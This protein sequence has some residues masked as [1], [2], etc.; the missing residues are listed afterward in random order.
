MLPFGR[1]AGCWWKGM[2]IA[3]P[4]DLG[5]ALAPGGCPRRPCRCFEPP[6]VVRRSFLDGPVRRSY[7][8]VH[9]DGGRRDDLIS[10]CCGVCL[11]LRPPFRGR[12]SAE[13]GSCYRYGHGGPGRGSPGP[14]PAESRCPCVGRLDCGK[15]GS[16]WCAPAAV[17]VRPGPCPGLLVARA[18]FLNVRHPAAHR[19]GCVLPDGG[20]L[21]VVTRSPFAPLLVRGVFVSLPPRDAPVVAHWTVVR[22]FLRLLRQRL[23]LSWEGR[24]VVLGRPTGPR[25]FPCRIANAGFWVLPRPRP[26][27]CL[28]ST[29]YVSGY[30]RGGPL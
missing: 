25:T 11:V 28:R 18:D 21:P 24:V 14:C 4:F 16:G 8:L 10:I 30:V 1:P 3:G 27:V 29:S 2:R 9:P 20:V 13:C 7:R 23:G 22:M 12:G 15:E 6:F 17:V 26:D 19:P 5:R